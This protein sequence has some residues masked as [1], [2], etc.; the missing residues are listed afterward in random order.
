[1]EDLRLVHRV[2]TECAPGRRPALSGAFYS[3]IIVYM[4][5]TATIRVPTETRDSLAEIAER[6]GVSISRLLTR[7]ATREHLHAIYEVER[8]AIR[9]DLANPAVV[10]EYE[11]W[12][13]AQVDGIG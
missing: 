10:A 1:L 12:D 7:F 9:R 2:R 5:E 13:E 8:E 3:A 4:A 6:Q 11:L